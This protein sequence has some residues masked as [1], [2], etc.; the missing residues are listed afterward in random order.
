ME[1]VLLSLVAWFFGDCR[2]NRLSGSQTDP[3]NGYN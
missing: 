3:S 2:L 1:S